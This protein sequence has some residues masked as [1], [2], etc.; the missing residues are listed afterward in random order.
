MEAFNLSSRLYFWPF[1]D[2]RMKL[3]HGSAELCVLRDRNMYILQSSDLYLSNQLKTYLYFIISCVLNSELVCDKSRS[4]WFKNG[5]KVKYV[6]VLYTISHG[7]TAADHVAGNI[8]PI[9][10]DLPESS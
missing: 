6:Y 2:V 10:F 9:S 1:L 5:T 7:Q 8:F 3:Q 4:I